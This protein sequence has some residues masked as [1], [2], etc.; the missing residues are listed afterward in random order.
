MVE[1]TSSGYTAFQEDAFQRNAFQIFSNVGYADVSLVEIRP[2]YGNV[3]FEEPNLTLAR[4]SIV[5]ISS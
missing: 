2:V 1:I 4:V 5:E 3:S